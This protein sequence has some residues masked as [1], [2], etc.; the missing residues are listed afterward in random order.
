MITGME[1]LNITGNNSIIQSMRKKGI[2]RKSRI[3]NKVISRSKKGFRA[4]DGLKL[5]REIKEDMI[6]KDRMLQLILDEEEKRIQEIE[7]KH[8]ENIEKIQEIFEL[9]KIKYYE[10]IKDI[11]KQYLRYCFR[12]KSNKF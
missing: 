8:S 5:Q 4:S 7:A 9:A 11:E 10:R 12:I 2:D 6:K 1:S 3:L